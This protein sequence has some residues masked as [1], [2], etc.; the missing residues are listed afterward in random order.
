MRNGGSGVSTLGIILVIVGACML[1]G[2]FG[3]NIG[4]IIALSIAGYLVYKGWTM[5]QQGESSG[6]RGWGIGLMVIGFLWMSG[7]FHVILGIALAGVLIYY[8]WKM[9]KEKRP[10]TAATDPMFGEEPT[11]SDPSMRPYSQYDDLD[12]WEQSVRHNRC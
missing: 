7:L 3:V 2:Q 1:L 10:V 12:A 9:I 5:Y 4:W 11:E 6:K 8:G